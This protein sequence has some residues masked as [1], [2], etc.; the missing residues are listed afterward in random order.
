MCEDTEVEVVQREYMREDTEVDTASYYLSTQTAA[1]SK[2]AT[3]QQPL[4]AKQGCF[5]RIF[6]TSITLTYQPVT[7]FVKQIHCMK[8]P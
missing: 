5:I 8:Y 2:R 1:F 7:K 3:Q 4:N 6:K